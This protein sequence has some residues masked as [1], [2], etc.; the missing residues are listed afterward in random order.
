MRRRYIVT[1]LTA[2]G[3]VGY[4]AL[5]D[6]STAPDNTSVDAITQEADYIIEGV[7][8]EFYDENGQLDRQIE[9]NSAR[10]LPI[11]DT[12]KLVNPSV[13]LRDQQAPQ[14]S[15]KSKEG[16]L[17]GD[18]TLTLDG[19]VNITPMEGNQTDLSL[20]TQHISIDLNKQIADTDKEVFIESPSTNIYSVG[21]NMNLVTQQ[22]QL[23]SEV[24]GQH[25]PKAQ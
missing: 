22:V 1:I 14:W 23:K 6:D 9:A 13:I 11:D 2:L 7:K 20:R 17:L 21:M 15:V 16:L 24:R 25:D 19:D 5:D 4:L 18:K 8:A 3:I 12:T 10:H